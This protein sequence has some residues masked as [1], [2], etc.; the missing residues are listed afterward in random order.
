MNW[1]ILN[2]QCDVFA[3]QSQH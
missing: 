3:V 1:K 2:K